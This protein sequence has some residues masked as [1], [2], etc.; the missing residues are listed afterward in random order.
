[1]HLMSL[2]NLITEANYSHLKDELEDFLEDCVKNILSPDTCKQTK[3]L[4]NDIS[5]KQSAIITAVT[6]AINW[7]EEARKHGLHKVC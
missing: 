2:L 3:L 7:A 6:E 5:S 4:E 1:M